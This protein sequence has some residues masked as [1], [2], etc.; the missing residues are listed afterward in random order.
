[1]KKPPKISSPDQIKSFRD[2]QRYFGI[3]NWD[4]VIVTDG[5]ATTMD[6][7]GGWGAVLIRAN[8]L[9]R[10]LVYGGGSHSTNNVAEMMAVYWPLM[11]LMEEGVGKKMGG[12]RVHVI[13]DSQYV[14]DGLKQG[15]AVWTAKL[16]SNR[17]L[18]IAMHHAKR[19]GIIIVPHF[20]PRDTI[21]LN[22][23]C[24]DLANVSRKRMLRDS[25]QEELKWN[26][27]ET[28]PT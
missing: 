6:R 17:S 21:D 22:R 12:Y 16:K 13:S 9:E 11:L 4:A 2:L 27:N 19:R 8:R 15:S 26:A 25:V 18:W 5:S 20:V 10:Q 3:K 24:H 14:V 7:P 28:T 1:M 23:L